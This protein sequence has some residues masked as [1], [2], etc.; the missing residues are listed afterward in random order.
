MDVA[1]LQWGGGRKANE[2]GVGVTGVHVGIWG[3]ATVEHP[4]GYCLLCQAESV[5]FQEA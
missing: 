2:G 5:F 4:P 3:W 1:G